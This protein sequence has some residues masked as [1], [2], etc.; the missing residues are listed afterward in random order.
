MSDVERAASD[1]TQ[2]AFPRGWV[3]SRA[4]L[5]SRALRSQRNTFR[6]MVGVAVLSLAC[7]VAVVARDYN[8]DFAQMI[9]LATRKAGPVSFIHVPH[10]GDTLRFTLPELGVPVVG[11]ERCYKYMHKETG[12]VNAILFRD[13]R[14]H[15]VSRFSHCF[16]NPHGAASMNPL[17]GFP[18]ATRRFP[19]KGWS[20]VSASGSDTS[21]WHRETVASTVSAPSTCRRGTSPAAPGTRPGQGAHHGR[22]AVGHPGC[23]GARR[24]VPIRAYLGVN[25][26]LGPLE[27]LRRRLDSM[28]VVG[29]TEA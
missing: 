3:R 20:A 13:P 14:E 6:A 19:K 17:W 16:S 24:V 2:P 23:S 21:T 7:T 18:K 5:A 8:G 27:K 4:I 28:Q 11:E 26:E 25:D 10:G 15:V 22:R 29:V 9:R 1:E 12:A